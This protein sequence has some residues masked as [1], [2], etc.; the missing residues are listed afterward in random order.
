[1]RL[2]IHYDLEDAVRNV[3]EP[4]GPFKVIRN[5]R[6]TMTKVDLPLLF[7]VDFLI[8]RNVIQTL[9]LLGFQFSLLLLLD[10]TVN[11]VGKKDPYQ[12]QSVKDL[13]SLVP[14]LQSQNLA[15]DYSLLTQAKKY[16]KR[17]HVQ[18]NEHKFPWMMEEKFLL[19][20][21]Y[22]MHGKIQDASIMQEHFV[23][24]DDYTLS[25]GSPN[26]VYRLSYTEA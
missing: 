18:L 10:T 6:K 16:E 20:P 22:G 19:V 1:M 13:K 5:N 8:K 12:E 25:L 2:V 23:G 15:T 7:T 17:V 11:T 4:F 24:S 14:L 9:P 3:N 21:T 26:K